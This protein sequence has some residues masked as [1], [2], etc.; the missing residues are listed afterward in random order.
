[1]RIF[2]KEYTVDELRKLFI[3][4]TKN[5]NENDF[6]EFISA[7]QKTNQ[8]EETKP[9]TFKPLIEVEIRTPKSRYETI[10]P[11]KKQKGKIIDEG[12]DVSED[13][14]SVFH[15]SRGRIC[16]RAGRSW[17]ERYGTPERITLLKIYKDGE[18]I[19]IP[20]KEQPV[21]TATMS[22][23][24]PKTIEA[25]RAE[26][27]AHIVKKY[28]LTGKESVRIRIDR[29]VKN[30]Y[31]FLQLYGYEIE[32]LIF[33]GETRV[34]KRDTRHIKG[35][36]DMELHGS[37]F[38]YETKGDITDEFRTRGAKAL[39]VL[40]A[41]LEKFDE[42]YSLLFANSMRTDT[43][44][45][46]E[47]ASVIP[48]VKKSRVNT[49]FALRD[50]SKDRRILEAAGLLPEEWHKLGLDRILEETDIKIVT[51]NRTGSRNFG[52]TPS[53]HA[54]LKSGFR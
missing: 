38:I 19:V 31:S 48:L 54:S 22:A 25:Y 32:V 40:Q 43:S 18:E 24:L 12:I 15:W 30:F 36:R 53:Y 29:V 7:M 51:D 46:S 4:E 14:I 52:G 41:W 21:I 10:S 2:P 6:K 37:R 42:G 23:R 9:N 5:E 8:L 39:N 47:G 49:T 1:M 34:A 33:F 13:T 44:P 50:I 35:L 16:L 28:G 20:R 26:I 17:V 27:P 3:K 45:P 11:E